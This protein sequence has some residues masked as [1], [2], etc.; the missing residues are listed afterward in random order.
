MRPQYMSALRYAELRE[1]AP[2]IT[3]EDHKHLA[4][5]RPRRNLTALF[6]KLALMLI[7]AE[8]DSRRQAAAMDAALRRSM[9]PI[10][11]SE[12]EQRE[13][14]GEYEHRVY[15]GPAA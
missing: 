15:P 3:A 8:A 1:A 10:P 11:G 13:A 12:T 6:T 9:A 5:F 7:G 2:T 4:G 14:R